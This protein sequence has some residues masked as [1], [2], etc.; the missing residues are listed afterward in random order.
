MGIDMVSMKERIENKLINGLSPLH[1]RVENVSHLH[2]GHAG[3]DGSGESHFLIDI[4]SLYFDGLSR[5]H[6]QRLIFK[7]LEDEM[8]SIHALSIRR[9]STKI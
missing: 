2:A 9:C 5:V 1:L 3:D 6:R 7:A 8:K 4:V